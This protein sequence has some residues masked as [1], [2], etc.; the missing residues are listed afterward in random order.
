MV[1]CVS[2]TPTEP[3]KFKYQG[4]NDL[5][6]ENSLLDGNAGISYDNGTVTGPLKTEHQEK[7]HLENE[8]LRLNGGGDNSFNSQEC[9]FQS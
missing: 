9:K 2:G 1:L 3:F 4:T 8:P 6:P 5:D 7:G